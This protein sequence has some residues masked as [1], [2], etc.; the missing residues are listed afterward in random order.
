MGCGKTKLRTS[1]VN[2]QAKTGSTAKRHERVRHGFRPC[3]PA[4]RIKPVYSYEVRDTLTIVAGRDINA[5]FRAGEDISISVQ[6]VCLGCNCC[7]G[8]DAMTG[9]CTVL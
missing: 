4:R 9:K 1:Q 8:R 2:T 6:T 3:A 5:L 7:P